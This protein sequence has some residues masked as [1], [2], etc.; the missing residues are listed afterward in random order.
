M[1]ALRSKDL[2]TRDNPA[3]PPRRIAGRPFL[4]SCPGGGIGRHTALRSQVLRVRVPSRAPFFCKQ[5]KRAGAI[6][7]EA[8][9]S[10]AD[11]LWISCTG[12]RPVIVS[13]V[14]D[15]PLWDDIEFYPR[16]I[17]HNHTP[18]RNR[19]VCNFYCC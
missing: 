4:Y 6:P 9:G 12:E 11:P 17:V 13:G 18:W 10:D 3:S 2:A 5:D 1:V 15:N 14:K 7:L 19:I 16:S 8:L